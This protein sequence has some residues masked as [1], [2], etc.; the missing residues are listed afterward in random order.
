MCIWF[1]RVS[2]VNSLKGVVSD[3]TLLGQLPFISDVNSEL[4]KIKKQK[5]E[6]MALYDFGGHTDIDEDKEGDEEWVHI[7]KIAYQE[8]NKQLQIKQPNK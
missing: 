5:E 8:H 6:N 4:E 1:I 2:L 3:S 7:G